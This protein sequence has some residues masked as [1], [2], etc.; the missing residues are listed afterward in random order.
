MTAEIE[1]LVLEHLRAI[2]ADIADLKREVIGNSVQLSAMGQQPAGLSAAPYAGKSDVD[3]IKRRL[4]P[5]HTEERASPD[6]YSLLHLIAGPALPAVGYLIHGAP[7]SASLQSGGRVR[8]VKGPPF[9]GS[10]STRP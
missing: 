5:G 3:A 6:A 10:A 8:A 1:S 4:H 2:R 9:R 7:S